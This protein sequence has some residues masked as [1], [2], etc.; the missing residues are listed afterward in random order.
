MSPEVEH[1]KTAILKHVK[2]LM[3]TASLD[4]K[5]LVFRWEE[6]FDKTQWNLNIFRGR[7]SRQLH[8]REEDV[9]AWAATPEVA[10]RHLRRILHAI[11]MLKAG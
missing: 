3:K 6:N 1:G 5:G 2:E 10:G 4:P 11:E 8:F 7:K 9:E